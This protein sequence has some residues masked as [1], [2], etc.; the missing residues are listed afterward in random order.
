MLSQ[1]PSNWECDVTFEYDED[2]PYSRLVT[3]DNLLYCQLDTLT[4]A[5]CAPQWK[6]APVST[7]KKAI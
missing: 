7:C 3:V 1:W 5:V 4:F 2:C 6:P